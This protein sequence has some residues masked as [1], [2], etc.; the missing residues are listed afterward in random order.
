MM[1]LAESAKM[2]SGNEGTSRS[3]MG[4]ED[5]LRAETERCLLSKPVWV[6]IRPQEVVLSRWS[7]PVEADANFRSN[8]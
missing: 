1:L 8:V 2:E 7:Y 5:I 6:K 4:S 3:R